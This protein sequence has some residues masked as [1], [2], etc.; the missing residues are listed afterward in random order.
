[1]IVVTTVLVVMV[2]WLAL[3]A[4]GSQGP[5]AIM[6]NQLGIPPVGS[7]TDLTLSIGVFGVQTGFLALL[8]FI[9][10]RAVVMAALTSMAVDVLRKGTRRDGRS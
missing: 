6:I 5:F 2:E 10:V 1:M 4:F 9:V 7:Y 8:G 3:V